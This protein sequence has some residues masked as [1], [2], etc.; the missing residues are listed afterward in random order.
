MVFSLGKRLLSRSSGLDG[1]IALA[2]DLL[3]EPAG[4]EALA[5]LAAEIDTA[6]SK[7]RPS[8]KQGTVL[9]LYAS[10]T[11]WRRTG[12][13]EAPFSNVTEARVQF[14]ELEYRC[15]VFDYQLALARVMDERFPDAS[16]LRKNRRVLENTPPDAP[17]RRETRDA[18][19]DFFE[20][21]GAERTIVGFSGLNGN[22]LGIGWTT[23]YRAVAAPT[24]SNLIVLKDFQRRLYLDGLPS[25]GDLEASVAALAAQLEPYREQGE[26]I[27][28]GGSG[29]TFGALMFAA[30][31]AGIERVV[32]LSGPTSLELGGQNEDK[33][34]YAE[35]LGLIDAGH[36][37][38]ADIPSL[39]RGS[40]IRRVDFFVSGGNGFDMSQ[41]TNLLEKTDVVVPHIYDTSDHVMTDLTV[42]DG[43]LCA[44]VRGESL[45]PVD[46]R[47]APDHS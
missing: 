24:L 31:I 6:L 15:P 23:F 30:R 5:L 14:W 36:L 45:D 44:V 20:T 35:I 22:C 11:R 1:T 19:V 3:W 12:V 40:G 25:L 21:P 2:R 18:D 4:E 41:M 38:H 39:V 43:R 10:L 8:G 34:V 37:P 13:F 7:G 29:G 33:Q 17:H 26:V 42:E 9:R 46:F 28:V 32:A 16:G 27:F 47:S